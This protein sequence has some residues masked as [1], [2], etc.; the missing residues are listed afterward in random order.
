MAQLEETPLKCSKCKC[1]EKVKTAGGHKCEEAKKKGMN[2][3]IIREPER[4]YCEQ[5]T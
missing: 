2:M 5:L 1:Y 4:T 3:D